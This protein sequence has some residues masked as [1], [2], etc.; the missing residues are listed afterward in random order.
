MQSERHVLRQLQTSATSQALKKKERPPSWQAEKDSPT[1]Y[2]RIRHVGGKQVLE[3][4][5]KPQLKRVATSS[6]E[7][8]MQ[9]DGSTANAS[10][11]S[12]GRSSS[13]ESLEDDGGTSGEESTL[14]EESASE[15]ESTS[16]EDSISGEGNTSGEDE[17]SL[18]AQ[19]YNRLT[20]DDTRSGKCITTGSSFCDNTSNDSSLVHHHSGISHPEEVDPLSENSNGT[21]DYTASST[22]KF[23]D[24]DLHRPQIKEENSGCCKVLQSK[25]A[26]RGHKIAPFFAQGNAIL[27]YAREPQEFAR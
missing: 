1:K 13:R 20:R 26:Q 19:S 3:A 21:S 7:V 22:P 18:D 27:E 4:S 24:S 2:Q 23:D 6:I 17:R 9:Q 10:D 5:L 11:L 12:V 25:R 16:G 14:D 15:E 8:L